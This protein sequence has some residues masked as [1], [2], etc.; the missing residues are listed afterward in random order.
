MASKVG[1]GG[2]I[3][4]TLVGI[5]LVAAI[6]ILV[7]IIS[8]NTFTRLDLTE[9][10]EFTIS[11]ATKDVLHDLSD[12]VTITMY[13][14]EDVPTQLSTLRRQIS[15]IL[16]EYR[17]F[18]RGNVQVD[19]VDPGDDAQ[20]QQKLRALGIPQVTVQTL[21]KDQFQ[22]LNI[23]LGMAISYLDRQEVI[24]V[25][26]D[27]YTLE[28]DLTAAILKVGREE[29]YVIGI[30]GG[31]TQHQLGQQL[32]SINE[33]LMRGGRIIFLVDGIRLPEGG[34]LQAFPVDSGLQDLLAH[35][36]VRV[37]KAL[38]LDRVNATASFSSGY[39]R[40]TV[41]YPYWV[42]TV[43][44]LLN[45]EHPIT[46]RLESLIL[47]WVAPLEVDLEIDAGDPL[48]H[49]TELERSQREA[50]AERMGVELPEDST[51]VAPEEGAAS[52]PPEG[53]APLRTASV[54]ARTSPGAWTVS[55]YY[56]LN[57]Q[58][59]FAPP[60]GGTSSQI[61]AVSVSGRFESFYTDREV[62]SLTPAGEKGEESITAAPDEV[63]LLESPD[64]RIIVV[65]NG[66]FATDQ[67]LAQFPANS[68]FLLNAIDWMTLGDKLITIRSRGAT[69]RPLRELSD[70][71]KS[72]I[73]LVG[74]LGT[75][76]LVIAFGL[77]RF[78]LRRK[79]SAARETAAQAG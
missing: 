58:Q 50:L 59:R 3:T 12:L 75:P 15:D 29:E 13:M 14:S 8:A 31:P 47:P 19:F 68:V 72:S 32:T 52:E 48:A 79:A 60:E 26:Q 51:E 56:D 64:T 54:M 23:Y 40:Y 39:V 71:S 1:R 49:I 61:T 35:Y 63:P 53:E 41:P 9:G 21:K 27:T 30:L 25:V 36:G 42:R 11:P 57:P 28:Y 66:L 46:N 7:N 44:D 77:V 74:I 2:A 33:F 43:P 38:L 17:N 65:G 62:P 20:M 78:G 5:I 55:G 22:S 34:G 10:K 70:A 45:T 69:D 76:I 37:Q 24:P 73:K 4:N 67:F 18:G 16:D 6:L